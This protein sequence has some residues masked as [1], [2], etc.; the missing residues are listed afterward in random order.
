MKRR[1]F[2]TSWFVTLLSHAVRISL[3]LKISSPF[4]GRQAVP[5]VVL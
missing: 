4:E 2:Q 3:F 5:S 1:D